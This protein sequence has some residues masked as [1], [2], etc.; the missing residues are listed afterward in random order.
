MPADSAVTLRPIDSRDRLWRRVH[1][2]S[3]LVLPDEWGTAEKLIYLPARFDPARAFVYDVTPQG[4]RRAQQ[5]DRR[6]AVDHLELSSPATRCQPHRRPDALRPSRTSFE[7][8]RAALLASARSRGFEGEDTR[9]RRKFVIAGQSGRQLYGCGRRRLRLAAHYDDD[10]STSA[11]EKA[12]MVGVLLY[13]GSAT[14]GAFCARASRQVAAVRRRCCTSSAP[15]AC[16]STTSTR[17]AR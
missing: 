11:E 15:T 14:N 9:C 5:R 8:D 6:R 17:R 12:D 1:R 7:G 13:D 16:R 3:G 4:T 2:G 10:P